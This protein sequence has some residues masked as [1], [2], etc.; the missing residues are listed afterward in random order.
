MRVLERR[1]ELEAVPDGPVHA[2]VG[3]RGGA[4]DGDRSDAGGQPEAEHRETERPVVHDVVGQR[5][6][7]R[8]GKV[9]GGRNVRQEQQRQG[10]PPPG[11]ELAV[12]DQP[13]DEDRRSLQSQPS[14]DRD[15]RHCRR[16]H[17]SF[18]RRHASLLV[19]HPWMAT[20]YSLDG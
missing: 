20:L 5:A 13:R 10:Q 8:S 17:R 6:D 16:I 19:A 4:D 12:H 18:D 11:T 7:P 15:G 3:D 1:R 14:A 9:A 2:H